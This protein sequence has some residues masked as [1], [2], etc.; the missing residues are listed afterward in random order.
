MSLKELKSVWTE[1]GKR[2]P[3]WAVLTDPSRKGGKWDLDDFF[4]TGREEIKDVLEHIKPNIFDRPK[5]KALD[6]GCGAGRLTQALAD[7]FEEVVGVDISPTMIEQ[8]NTLNRRGPACRFLLN[9]RDDLRLFPDNTFDFVYS[10]ITLQHIDPVYSRKYIPELVRVLAPGGMLVFQI[11]ERP[12]RLTDRFFY[13]LARHQWYRQERKKAGDIIMEMHGLPRKEVIRLAEQGGGALSLLRLDTASGEK[14]L[15]WKYYV[16]KP[17]YDLRLGE[18]I[19]P[20]IIRGAVK[21]SLKLRVENRTPAA[22]GRDLDDPLVK[23]GAKLF[24]NRPR[25]NLYSLKEFRAELPRPFPAGTTAE[26]EFV[27]DLAGFVPAYYWLYIDFV[28]EGKFWFSE[29]GFP[30]LLKQI[31]ITG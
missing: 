13:R 4:R 5:R 15:A 8:A 16:H 25:I 18:A 24:P 14:W 27:L 10:S 7:I 23:L 26:A 20:K 30:P 22:A 31:Q 3:L 9:D 11:P 12:V 29:L 19:G 28:W 6:F 17:R 2:D 1:F 21:S